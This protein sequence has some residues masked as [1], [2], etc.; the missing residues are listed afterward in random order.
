M[1][2][3]ELRDLVRLQLRDEDKEY[4]PDADLTKWINVG[5]RE[6]ADRLGLIQGEVTAGT[7]TSSKF[8][9]PSE[10]LAPLYLEVSGEPVEFYDVEQFEQI[11]DG[12]VG[13][14]ASGAYIFNGYVEIAPTVADGTGYA[15]RYEK[16]P[17]DLAAD[18]NIS[19]LPTELHPRL[20]WYATAMALLKT[21][22]EGLAD[23]FMNMFSS[24][25]PPAG[26][27][28]G[29]TRPGPKRLR[30]EPGPFDNTGTHVG[31]GGYG[32]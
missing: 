16:G 32:D 29:R 6:L 7:T 24:D 17:T 8:A 13:A 15:F 4:V 23:R 25:L 10:Y 28:S 9:L 26:L 27:G 5:Q 21:R 11:R 14:P 12:N 30:W 2:L 20:A 22:E 18:G 1:T 3:A 19:V 31:V